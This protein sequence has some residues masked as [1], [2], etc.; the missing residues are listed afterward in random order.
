M[1][2]SA[3]SDV[4][5]TLPVLPPSSVGKLPSPA[6]LDARNAAPASTILR[7]LGHFFGH[8]AECLPWEGNATLIGCSLPSRRTVKVTT[9]SPFLVEA[10]ARSQLA[11]IAS[12]GSALG[13]NAWPSTPTIAS[14]RRKPARSAGPPT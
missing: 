11:T 6:C 10:S 2:A 4:T 7:H 8:V 9:A 1:S 14:L 12:T 3:E 5:T 13:S